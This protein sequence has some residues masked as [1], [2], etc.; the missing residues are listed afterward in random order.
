MNTGYEVLNPIPHYLGVQRT[1]VHIR[2]HLGVD[3]EDTHLV[4]L[5]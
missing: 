5:G 4:H 2:L 1:S 3:L